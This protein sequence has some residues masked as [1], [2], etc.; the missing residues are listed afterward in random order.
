MAA[1]RHLEL[2]E[3]VTDASLAPKIF[4]IPDISSFQ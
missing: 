4:L 2:K 3:P 1:G